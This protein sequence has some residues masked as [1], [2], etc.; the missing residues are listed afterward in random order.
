MIGVGVR[1]LQGFW[2]QQCPAIGAAGAG[3][4]IER[5]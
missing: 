3:N 5:Q 2:L 4:D 1:G